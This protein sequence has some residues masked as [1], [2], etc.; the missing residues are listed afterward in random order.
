MITLSAGVMQWVGAA[1]KT[2]RVIQPKIQT[3]FVLNQIQ[4][5]HRIVTSGPALIDV[6]SVPRSLIGP[7]PLAGIDRIVC[8]ELSASAALC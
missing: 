8:G 4:Q 2:D 1:A 5:N 6:E 3:I 7:C